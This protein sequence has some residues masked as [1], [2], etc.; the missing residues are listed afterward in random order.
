MVLNLLSLSYND[1]MCLCQHLK[2]SKPSLTYVKFPGVNRKENSIKG[3]HKLSR[4]GSE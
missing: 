2:T 3:S 4:S 1:P